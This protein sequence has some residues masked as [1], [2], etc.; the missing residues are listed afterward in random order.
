MSPLSGNI[1]PIRCDSSTDLP[2]PDGPRT[3]V[4]IPSGMP[5]FRPFMTR[6]EP[7]DL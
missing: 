7:N 6:L 5:T 1:R 4:I 2:V 3:T